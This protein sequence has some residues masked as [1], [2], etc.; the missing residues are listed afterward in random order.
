MNFHQFRIFTINKVS[1]MKLGARKYLVVS[2]DP[3]KIVLLPMNTVDDI[4]AKRKH[5]GQ[6]FEKP[7]M[8]Y[9][10]LGNGSQGN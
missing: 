1:Y 2:P 9:V 6:D 3:K 10:S 5:Y 8:G 7:R 4:N